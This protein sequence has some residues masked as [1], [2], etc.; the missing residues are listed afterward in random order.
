MMFKH[1]VRTSNSSVTQ[2]LTLT[3]S[4]RRSVGP[5]RTET[6]TSDRKSAPEKPVISSKLPRSTLTA[7]GEVQLVGHLLVRARGLVFVPRLTSP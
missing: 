5:P 7:K 3:V 1:R 4:C 6:P 2:T